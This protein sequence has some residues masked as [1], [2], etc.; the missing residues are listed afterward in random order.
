M[1]NLKTLPFKSNDAAFEYACKFFKDEIIKDIGNYG[2]ILHI[3]TK[4]E[5]QSFL[6]KIAS[7]KIIKNFDTKGILVVGVKHPK[8]NSDLRVGDFVLWVCNDKNSADFPMG[9][10][11][12]KASRI[13]DTET[14][15]FI[16][17]E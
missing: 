15:Q 6:I 9:F 12:E 1:N 17:E 8:V 3:D 5:P 2:I 13:L 16:F 7:P 11:V 4:E 14:H 10:I